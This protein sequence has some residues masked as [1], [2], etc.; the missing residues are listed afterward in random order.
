MT[1]DSENLDSVYSAEDS[2]SAR[3]A[4]EGWAE[5]YDAENIG[6]GYR[7]PGI[8]CAMLARHAGANSGTIYDAACGTGI[9][10]VMLQVPDFD[11]V[12][13]S[14]L[15]PSVLKYASNISAYQKLY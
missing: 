14:D 15:F 6:N 3:S 9:V 4:Y 8:G 13:G 12:V 2:A 1:D 7:V 5:G 10:G 11:S